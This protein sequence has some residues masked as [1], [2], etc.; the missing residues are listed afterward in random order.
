[1]EISPFC[2]VYVVTLCKIQHDKIQI[3]FI[4]VKNKLSW[5]TEL[6]MKQAQP[7]LLSENY[8]KYFCS[9]NKIRMEDESDGYLMYKR[10]L[11]IQKMYKRILLLP[12]HRVDY[13]PHWATRI[14]HSRIIGYRS[15][16][17]LSLQ[18]LKTSHSAKQD[19]N[20]TRARGIWYL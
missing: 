4:R 14:K 12:K 10:I 8:W 11:N 7:L 15:N 19:I 2:I 17:H 18:N 3:P 1:M 16:P 9:S 5:K 13:S 20:P 6:H